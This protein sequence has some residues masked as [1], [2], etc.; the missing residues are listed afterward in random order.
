MEK[1][2]KLR[3][4][5]KGNCKGERMSTAFFSPFNSSYVVD[6]GVIV[7]VAFIYRVRFTIN[8]C[9]VAVIGKKSVGGNG[10]IG[11]LSEIKP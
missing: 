10:S 11:Y 7:I 1:E 2:G 5:D 3:G 6:K 9:P 4:S 8:F